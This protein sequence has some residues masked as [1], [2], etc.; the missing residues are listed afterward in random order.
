MAT[1]KWFSY[2][3]NIVL[4]AIE[5]GLVAI[6]RLVLVTFNHQMDSWPVGNQIF[7]IAFKLEK[8]QPKFFG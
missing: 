2:H 3:W 6:S 7:L 1:K 5:I 4:L 8:W